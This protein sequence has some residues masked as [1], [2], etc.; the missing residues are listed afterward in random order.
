MDSTS[1]VL[2]LSAVHA[3]PQSGVAD[4]NERLL[5]DPLPPQDKRDRVAAS[6]SKRVM[7]MDV[8]QALRFMALHRPGS[9]GLHALG[10]PQ[11]LHEEW[12]CESRG[13]G[14]IG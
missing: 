11:N 4:A 5:L 3:L 6:P 10:Q 8:D 14:C 2:R 1:A 13:T 12:G 7:T 9:D